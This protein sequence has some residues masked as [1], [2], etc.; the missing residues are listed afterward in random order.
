MVCGIAEGNEYLS[1]RLGMQTRQPLKREKKLKKK[2][3]TL[4]KVG[5]PPQF[6]Q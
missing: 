6:E 2:C 3:A 1:R 4:A 5:H